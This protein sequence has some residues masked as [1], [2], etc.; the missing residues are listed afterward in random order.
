MNFTL[1]AA[2]HSEQVVR[3][4]RF[5]GCVQPVAD[6]A[7]ALLVVHDLRAEHPGAAHVCWALMAGGESAANDDGE[8]GGTGP[9]RRD[10]ERCARARRLAAGVTRF[11][12][13]RGDSA[14]PTVSPSTPRAATGMSA[15]SGPRRAISAVTMPVGTASTPQPSNII[16]EAISRPRS[17]LG[18]RSPK[19][20]VAIVEIAQ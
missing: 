3:K 15:S 2:V 19:P 13:T 18:T 11:G 17:V 9:H 8:P 6:R 5:I 20:T 7:A 4:S 14:S 12:G 16:T 1:G 10:R